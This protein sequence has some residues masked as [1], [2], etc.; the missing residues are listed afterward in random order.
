MGVPPFGDSRTLDEL[1]RGI[2]D[3]A[4]LLA[5]NKVDRRD[6][7]ALPGLYREQWDVPKSANEYTIALLSQY[8]IAGEKGD[9]ILIFNTSPYFW[10]SELVTSLH[11]HKNGEFYFAGV[12]STPDAVE[13][14][15]PSVSQKPFLSKKV[16]R[17]RAVVA[18]ST[19]GLSNPVEQDWQL[20]GQLYAFAHELFGNEDITSYGR[21][22]RRVL[23]EQHR[24]LPLHEDPGRVCKEFIYDF[25]I[26]NSARDAKQSLYRDIRG[27]I[28]EP[29]RIMGIGLCGLL[30]GAISGVYSS[31]GRFDDAAKSGLFALAFCGLSIYFAKERA[32]RL[33]RLGK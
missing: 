17:A 28:G 3:T 16:D 33:R 31:V 18:T 8:E 27:R 19:H 9:N 24:L 13:E 30:S 11:L 10:S 26:G 15:I 20:R 4:V 25:S 12:R 6:Y 14:L 5:V 29:L 32:D 1:V 21:L 23:P 22:E 7:D 2:R